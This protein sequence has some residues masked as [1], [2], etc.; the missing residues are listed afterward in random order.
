VREKD[1]VITLIGGP[2]PSG[3]DAITIGRVVS[4]RRGAAESRHLMN[5]E[6]V[7]VRQW[8]RY[9]VLGFG[10]RYLGSYLL[11]RLQGYGHRT[12]YLRIPLEC[13]AEW[14]ARR[15]RSFTPSP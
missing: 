2:V 7:H 5:H 13:E 4:V 15:E 1:G 11:S 8:S 3:A 9:G 6:L 12:A 14:D 10:W